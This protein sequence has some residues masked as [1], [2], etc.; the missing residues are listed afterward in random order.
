MSENREALTTLD[1]EIK[2][3]IP[4]STQKKARAR[5]AFAPHYSVGRRI[6]YRRVA[7]EDWIASQELI[8][9]IQCSEPSEAAQVENDPR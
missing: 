8:G 6:Y 1:V 4:R 7:F 3:A 9:G 5:G 2:F